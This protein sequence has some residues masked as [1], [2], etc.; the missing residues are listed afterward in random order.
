MLNYIIFGLLAAI[1]FASIIT[2]ATEP[3][4]SINSGIGRIFREVRIR[5]REKSRSSFCVTAGV[6]LVFGLV[7]DENMRDIFVA[8][9][10]MLLT[11]IVLHPEDFIAMFRTRR[12]AKKAARLGLTPKLAGKATLAKL[13]RELEPMIVDVV[14]EGGKE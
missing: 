14:S 10:V 1:C 6:L 2:V 7:F 3:F 9:G 8:L 5:L 12:K 13:A 11:L 4:F